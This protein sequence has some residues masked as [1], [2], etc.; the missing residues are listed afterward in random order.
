MR[1]SICLAACLAL[2][3]ACERSPEPAEAP[4]VA[5][6]SYS[7][8]ADISGFY[9]P[10]SEE[11]LGPWSFSHVFIG[12]ATEF[13]SWSSGARS[14]T[15]APVTVEFSDATS[16]RV[17]TETGEGYS[18]VERVLPTSYSVSDG[19]IRFEGRSDKLGTVTFDGRL[20]AG[21]LA[22]ARRNLGD[23]GAVVTGRLTVDEMPP[24]TVRLRWWMGD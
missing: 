13:E 23:E 2:L 8:T 10:L 22:T 18:V 16:P 15:F 4:A 24:R 20:D 14:S 11:R 19:R 1:R 6:F 7:A 21:A 17:R 12:Q 9:R 5:A 3:A